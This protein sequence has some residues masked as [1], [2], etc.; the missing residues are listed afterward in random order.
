MSTQSTDSRLVLDEFLH[1]LADI[2]RYSQHTISNYRRDLE[3]LRKNFLSANKKT[4][5]DVTPSDVRLVVAKQHQKGLSGRSIARQLSALRSLYNWLLKRKR[6]T[7]NP[8]TDIRAPKD[9]KPLPATLDPEEVNQLLARN[10]DTALELRDKAMFELFYS[11]GL[12]LS[13]LVGIDLAD[14]DIDDRQV[15]VTGKGNKMRILPVGSK[16]I[17]A[18]NAWLGVRDPWLQGEQLALFISKKGRRISVRSVQDRLKKMALKTGL[19]R[20][21]YPHMLRHSFASHM[22]ESSGDLRAVQEMLGHADIST[23]QIYTH[24]DFQHLAAVYEKAHPRAK[25]KKGE[26]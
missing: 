4:W 2:K 3:S 13:E 1:E 12:R 9:R 11:S 10:A 14:L 21:C 8:A 26:E 16:A 18:L 5:Q 24:L 15:R 25:N 7:S 20:N 6:C 17:D 23:T 22:L 19:S